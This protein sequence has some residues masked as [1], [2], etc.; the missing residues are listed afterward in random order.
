VATGALDILAARI[1]AH[2]PH[3]SQS[4]RDA[5]ALFVLERL[6]GEVH[7][8]R[9]ALELLAHGERL[10]AEAELELATGTWGIAQDHAGAPK[11]VRL[12]DRRQLRGHAMPVGKRALLRWHA[13]A[14]HLARELR[15][16]AADPSG[17]DPSRHR[18]HLELLR[19]GVGR[20]SK[21]L[22]LFVALWQHY[23]A[24]GG[25]LVASSAIVRGDRFDATIDPITDP[26]PEMLVLE[27]HGI[28][29]RGLFELDEG[30][31]V[32]DGADGSSEIVRV[33][34]LDAEGTPADR[35][36]AHLAARR[37]LEAAVAG[38]TVGPTDTPTSPDVLLPVV[39]R[40]R[41]DLAR[42]TSAA[43]AIEDHRTTHVEA[44]EARALE[45]MLGPFTWLAMGWDTKGVEH[46]PKRVSNLH[47]ESGAKGANAASPA[48]PDRDGEPR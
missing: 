41:A 42:G 9:E 14:A 17:H 32:Y 40:Y 1:G 43:F 33:R 28:G 38:T 36:D 4:A 6:R 44:S 26:T 2:L 19:I 47:A 29:V 16:I 12:L 24:T 23:V 15:A 27:L 7:R 48:T 18:V 30:C 46:D 31:H 37:A 35:I 8:T 25:E 13:T 3:A 5:D 20:G 39:R 22:G 21:L 34:V 10:T 45:E 11:R